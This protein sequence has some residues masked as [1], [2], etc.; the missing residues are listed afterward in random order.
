MTTTINDVYD[1]AIADVFD[2]F[3]VAATFTPQVGDPV[4]CTVI[5][6]S[7]AEIQ[8]S[9]Y[10]SELHAKAF[11]VRYNLADT[12]QIAVRGD[13][14]TVGDETYKVQASVELKNGRMAE[15][16]ARLWSDYT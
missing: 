7:D 5:V 6:R 9:E 10:G 3:G 15:A 12:G 14:F 16:L 2:T 4:S 1:H 11:R 13:L 8:A